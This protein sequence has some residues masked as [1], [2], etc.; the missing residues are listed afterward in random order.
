MSGRETL[1]RDANTMTAS[2]ELEEIRYEAVRLVMALYDTGIILKDTQ[3]K[4][5]A[6]EDKLAD[7]QRSGQLFRRMVT[8]GKSWLDPIAPSLETLMKDMDKRPTL[9]AW[10]YTTTRKKKTL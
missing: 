8:S 2:M 1:E 6:T 10:E 4:L 9:E 7:T 3:K 5:H